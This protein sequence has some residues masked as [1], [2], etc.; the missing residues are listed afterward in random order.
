[1]STDTSEHMKP[2]LFGV[3]IWMS[4]E[5]GRRVLSGVLEH[6]RDATAAEV[7][8]I[9]ADEHRRPAVLAD[10]DGVIAVVNADMVQRWQAVTNVP[11]VAV[12]RLAEI[13]DVTTITA[14]Q[15]SVGQQAAEHFAALRLPSV[16]MCADSQEGDLD[17]CCQVFG[18]TS[19]QCGMTVMPRPHLPDR[20]KATIKAWL[21]TLPR[22]IGIFAGHDLWARRLAQCIEELGHRIPEDFAI[23]GLGNAPIT[24]RTG[25]IGLSSIALPAEAFGRQA[26]MTLAGIRAGRP[27]PGVSLPTTGVVARASTAIVCVDDPLVAEVAAQIRQRFFQAP[28]TA[29]LAHEQGIARRTLD[30]RFRAQM[31]CSIHEETTRC[32]LNWA[33]GML[34]DAHTPIQSI[35]AKLGLQMSNFSRFIK[36]KTGYSPRDFRERCLHQGN[37]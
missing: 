6:F 7:I 36:I 37:S 8:T 26:G 32:R 25:G 15:V 34:A 16:V 12:T 1:M 14:N 2:A 23:L 28:G 10:V 29:M 4:E 27:L 19:E 35:A 17:Y 9:P 33:T 21:A 24:C 11:M 13:P 22:P 5:F 30:Q 18:E 3:V 31:G 20:T